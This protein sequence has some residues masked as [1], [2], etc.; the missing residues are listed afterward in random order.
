MKKGLR[1]ILKSLLIL[2][3]PPI[4]Y[5]VL[6]IIGSLIPVNSNSKPTK[7]YMEI[8]LYKQ[9]MHTDIVL[10][11]HSKIIHWDTIFKPEHT[12]SKVENLKLIT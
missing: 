8:Y 7:S 3:A 6:A 9:D 11:V 2:I 5:L 10:P 12:L 4:I 1:I